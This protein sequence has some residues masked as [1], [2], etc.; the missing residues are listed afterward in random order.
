ML[1]LV[2]VVANFATGVTTQSALEDPS[3]KTQPEYYTSTLSDILDLM[4]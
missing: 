2:M 3:N 4:T 1:I